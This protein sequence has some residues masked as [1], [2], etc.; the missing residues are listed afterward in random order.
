MVLALAGMVLVYFGVG[1][2]LADTWRV[3]TTRTV[4]AS[5][6]QVAGLV[7]DFRSWAKWSSVEVTLGPQTTREVTG[8]PGTVGHRIAWSGNQGKA[9][10]TISTV[11]PGGID[12]DFHSQGPQDSQLLPRGKGRVEWVPDTG[13]CRVH[14]HDESTVDS[15]PGRWFLWFG[16]LQE[17]VR[18]MQGTSLSA[19]E[20][21]I[22]EGG[23]PSAK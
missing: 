7:R 22:S 21:A 17:R 2:I 10:L 3:D 11:A 1:C 9:M 16:A 20:Q 23:T 13:G 15:L 6:E 12:Y 14:W 18:E 8:E 4:R 5:P 19:M